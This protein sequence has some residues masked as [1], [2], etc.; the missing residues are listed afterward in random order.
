M[1]E[2]RSKL[3]GYGKDI[4]DKKGHFEDG[5]IQ[6]LVDN[7]SKYDAKLDFISYMINF[8]KFIDNT[9]NEYLDSEMEEIKSLLD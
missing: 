7:I 8:E 4:H 2:E 3:H 9:Q 5:I 6:P 1:I